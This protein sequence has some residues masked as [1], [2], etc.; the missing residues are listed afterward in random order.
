MTARQQPQR[1]NDET[2]GP[3]RRRGP[4]GRMIVWDGNTGTIDDL[5]DTI[6]DEI[7]RGGRNDQDTN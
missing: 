1:S 7:K 5:L 3:A 2:P 6:E 4:D